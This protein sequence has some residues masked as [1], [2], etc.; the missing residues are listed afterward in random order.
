LIPGAHRVRLMHSDWYRALSGCT[1]DLVVS[2][3]PYVAA[4]DPHLTQGDLRFEP[5]AALVGGNDGL[6]AIRQIVTGATAFLVPGGQLLFEHGHDQ[7]EAC[8]QLLATAGFSSLVGA[9]DLA[10]IPRVA[11]GRLGGTA[12]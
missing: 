5:A 3:P 7:A 11:G 10:G 1:F 9:A 6:D 12:S 4:A 8:R 2:N